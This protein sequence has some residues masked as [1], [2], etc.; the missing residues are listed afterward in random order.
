MNTD[1][2][3]KDIEKA[4]SKRSLLEHPFYLAWS[5]G[6]LTK[7]E[8]VGY[9]KEY[10]WAA[11]HVPAVM[12]AIIAHIP[13][14]MDKK[15]RATFAEH[16]KEEREHIAL[17]K[18]FGKSLD[19]SGRELDAY[20]PTKTVQKAVTN[21][22][23]TAGASFEEG[24]A[25][26]YAFECD[27]PAISRSKIAGLKKFYKMKSEDAQIYFKEHIKEEKHLRFWRRLLRGMPAT[28]RAA[29]L[30]AAKNTV[31]A[32]NGVLDGVVEKYCAGMVC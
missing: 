11:R 26:M 14:T 15:T 25:A 19:I 7:E 3:V 8:L 27:L 1:Q 16:L 2:L 18:R 24:I 12:K 32:K 22:I 23:E 20:V 4:V 31:D 9:A 30:K 17:W 21:M 28:K 10:Y 13:E 5:A 29:A 6:K